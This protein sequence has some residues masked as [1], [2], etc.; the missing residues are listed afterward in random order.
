MVPARRQ[1]FEEVK[2]ELHDEMALDLAGAGLFR[3]STVLE[4][5]LGGG[6]ALEQGAAIVGVEPIRAGRRHPKR[7]PTAVGPSS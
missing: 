2:Q 1:S 5:E 4:D 7:S 3:L 6:A